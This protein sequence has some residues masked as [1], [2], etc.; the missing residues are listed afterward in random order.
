VIED[1]EIPDSGQTPGPSWGQRLRDFVEALAGLLSTRAAI[2]REEL[3]GKAGDLGRAAVA[4]FFAAAFAW[5]SLLLLTAGIAALFSRLF[6]SAILGILVTFVLYAAVAGLAAYLGVRSVSR[7]DFKFPVTGEE[8]RKDWEA[9]A[10]P[11]GASPAGTPGAEAVAAAPS[12]QHPA[13][14]LESRFRAGS[15]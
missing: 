1:G 7:V 8:I 15:E 12:G 6:G 3:G 13:D 14:D 9:I 2:F 11:A 4:F 10:H 5:L